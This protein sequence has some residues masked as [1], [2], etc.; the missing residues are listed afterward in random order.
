MQEIMIT[1][2]CV[3]VQSI[4]K[5]KRKKNMKM[6]M[7]AGRPKRMTEVIVGPWHTQREREV[8]AGRSHMQNRAPRV[9]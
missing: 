9:I 2:V 3:H 6:Q 4:H 7:N 8:R 1:A 5:I